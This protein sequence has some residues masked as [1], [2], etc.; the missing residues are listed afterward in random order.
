MAGVLAALQLTGVSTVIATD[1]NDS[2]V[3]KSAR[4]IPGV[5]VLPVADLNALAVL[6]PERVL[7]TK[8]GLQGL[9]GRVVAG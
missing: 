9:V 7:F 6:S 4:N 2:N 1:G 3:Y 8:A 5:E